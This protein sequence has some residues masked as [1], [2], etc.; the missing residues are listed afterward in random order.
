MQEPKLLAD[1]VH[2]S[3][4]LPLSLE[5]VSLIFLPST[6]GHCLGLPC[7]PTL[8]APWSLLSKLLI[9]KKGEFQHKYW[10]FGKSLLLRCRIIHDPN[11]AFKRFHYG[12]LSS[13]C[14]FLHLLCLSYIFDGVK[15]SFKRLPRG[16]PVRVSRWCKRVSCLA[17]ITVSGLCLT[18]SLGH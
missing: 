13:L 4:V 18:F 1:P 6:L 10:V 17:Q 16:A 12:T 9:Q 7:C 3:R 14:N 11:F 2:S 15:L 5:R 8:V